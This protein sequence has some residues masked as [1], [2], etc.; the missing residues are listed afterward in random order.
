MASCSKY[1]LP[2]LKGIVVMIHL[3]KLDHFP[4]ELKTYYTLSVIENADDPIIKKKLLWESDGKSDKKSPM[5]KISIENL[6]LQIAG[7]VA[8]WCTG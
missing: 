3:Q 2:V 4:T 5:N 1:K 8:L 6:L 7:L